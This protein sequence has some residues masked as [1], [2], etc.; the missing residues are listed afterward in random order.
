[1]RVGD[2]ASAAWRAENTEKLSRVHRRPAASVQYTV[3]NT[4][5]RLHIVLADPGYT[6]TCP[7]PVPCM[8]LGFGGRVGPPAALPRISGCVARRCAARPP[9]WESHTAPMLCMV[10]TPLVF[11]S[12]FDSIRTARLPRFYS[13]SLDVAPVPVNDRAPANRCPAECLSWVCPKLSPLNH[14]V[15]IDRP[16]EVFLKSGNC[17]L[18][19]RG[20]SRLHQMDP[21]PFAPAFQQTVAGDPHPTIRPSLSNFQTTSLCCPS[22]FGD[23]AGISS[24]LASPY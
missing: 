21:L 10:R 14:F 20:A 24:L 23:P 6:C 7:R 2:I 19:H 8:C 13:M 16:L 18:A 15:G 11:T 3:D 17:G 1:M 12:W 4:T 22:P 9:S 5:C